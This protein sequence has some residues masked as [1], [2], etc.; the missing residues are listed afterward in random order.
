MNISLIFIKI[1]PY[2]ADEDVFGIIE[3]FLP[4][5]IDGIIG[6]IKPV[7]IG[8]TYNIP[9][10]YIE[11]NTLSITKAVKEALSIVDSQQKKQLRLQTLQTIIN[12]I[13][14][15][16]I[17]YNLNNQPIFSNELGQ[18]I[19]NNYDI[20]SGKRGQNK[21]INFFNNYNGKIL[22]I[23]NEKILLDVITLNLDNE[24]N[25]KVLIFQKVNSIE[26]TARKIRLA[27]YQKGLYAKKIFSDILY[28]SPQMKDVLKTAK[29]FAQSKSTVLIYGETGTG[30]EGLA[31]S[32]HNASP[33]RDKPFVSVNCASLPG[34]AATAFLGRI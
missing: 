34:N 14:E 6:D 18:Q 2:A 7:E 17:V 15:G 30:K 22:D 8:N 13:D 19:I 5:K 23:N 9:S 29:L 21:L 31:Q 26:K 27:L 11:S 16:I 1:C 25:N 28:N 12:N 4:K 10:I 32:S 24:R 3:G 20:L 33:R